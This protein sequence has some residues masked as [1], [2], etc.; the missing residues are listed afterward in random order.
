[1]L[2]ALNIQDFVIVDRL[3]LEFAPGFVVLTG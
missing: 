2:L 3:R 1:M